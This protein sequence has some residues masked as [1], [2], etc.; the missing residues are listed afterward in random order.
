M[1]A[2]LEI[3][4]D[5]KRYADAIND[6][7]TL[8]LMVGNKALG[9]EIVVDVKIDGENYSETYAHQARD[10]P[11]S[12]I[13]KVEVFSCSVEIFSERFIRQLAQYIEHLSNGF[14]I[15]IRFL[16]KSG[17]EEAGYDMLARSFATLSALKTHVE[18]VEDI[19]GKQGTAAA[20][21]ERWQKFQPIADHLHRE[22]IAMNPEYIA[23]L[24]E[25]EMLPFLNEWRKAA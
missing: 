4:G 22:Q 18:N 25:E 16:R 21:A 23:D 8:L 6:L 10:I 19:L 9:G 12:S 2:S 17:E 14:K 13:G 24:L 20:A 11:L 15:S 3:N 5:E 1:K 7:E